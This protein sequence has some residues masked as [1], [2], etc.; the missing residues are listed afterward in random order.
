M[1]SGKTSHHQ[2]RATH[3]WIRIEPTLILWCLGRW[4]I[5]NHTIC[6]TRITRFKSQKKGPAQLSSMRSKASRSLLQARGLIGAWVGSPSF[7]YF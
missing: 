3:S 1:T 2:Y 4:Y 7:P 6:V 5:C